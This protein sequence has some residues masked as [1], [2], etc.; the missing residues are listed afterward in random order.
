[1]VCNLFCEFRFEMMLA[2]GNVLNPISAIYQYCIVKQR[3][4]DVNV[5]YFFF[6]TI[7]SNYFTVLRSDSREM[8]MS[9]QVK[10]MSSIHCPITRKMIMI[11]YKVPII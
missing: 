3:I 7:F 1:M 10:G 11:Y 8:K 5:H 9:L 2:V 6:F 4:L